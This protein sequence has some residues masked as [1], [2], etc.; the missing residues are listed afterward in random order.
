MP[1]LF[2]TGTDTDCGKTHI[3]V[4]LLH[5][6]AARGE[7]AVGYKPVAAGCESGPEGL[8][9]ADARAL[10]AASAPGFSYA[11]V[12]PIALEPPIAPHVAA[13]DAQVAI[14]LQALVQGAQALEAKSDWVVVEGAGGFRVPLNEQ[15]DFAD[16]V[17]AAGWPVVLVVG[18]R[19]GCINHALL[20]VESIAQRAPLLGW[21]AN[22]LPPQQPRLAENI[23]AL[24]ARIAAPCLGVVRA[25]TP[26]AAAAELDLSQLDSILR[27]TP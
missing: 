13:D 16:L 7:R 3:S 21:V 8:S 6:L 19:L 14:D 20:S 4:A 9:N 11:E 23:A 5:A 27:K 10:L 18:M 25:P 2:V 15:E 22:V 12:N 17:V 26:Q 24:T 1:T